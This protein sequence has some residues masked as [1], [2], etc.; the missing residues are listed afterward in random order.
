[1][2]Q[3]KPKR[4]RGKPPLSDTEKTVH[5]THKMTESQ[6]EKLKALGG[7]EWLRAQIDKTKYEEAL[8]EPVFVSVKE[9]ETG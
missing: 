4:S 5:V 3:N 9:K 6:R 8:M 7:S 1:M 2:T